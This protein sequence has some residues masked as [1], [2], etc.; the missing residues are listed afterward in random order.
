[1]HVLEK[2]Q[3]VAVH[4]VEHLDS[5]LLPLDAALRDLPDLRLNA[6]IAGYI[7]DGQAVMVP[8]APISG[9]LRLY[10]ETGGFIGVGEILDDGRVEPRRLVN[11]QGE[12]SRHILRS[13]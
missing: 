8:Q 2:L 7:R 5:L 11:R 6:L 9:M 10:D 1:M 13:F 4:G 3:E 12:S